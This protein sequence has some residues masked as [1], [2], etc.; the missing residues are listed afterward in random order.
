MYFKDEENR[1]W[2]MSFES[3]TL[4]WGDWW[5][6]LFYWSILPHNRQSI[7]IDRSLL[8]NI[9]LTDWNKTFCISTE[10][11]RFIKVLTYWWIFTSLFFV[12]RILIIGPSVSNNLEKKL[13]ESFLERMLDFFW[14]RFQGL[15]DLFDKV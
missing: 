15:K 14:L 8:N 1:Q 2:E 5:T 13:K 6:M 11:V 9:F 4:I 7:S 10:G 12:S 3:E